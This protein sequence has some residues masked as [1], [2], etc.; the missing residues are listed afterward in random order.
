M[1]ANSASVFRTSFADFRTALKN[2]LG[3]YGVMTNP[4]STEQEILSGFEKLLE[5][6]ETELSEEH[7]IFIAEILVLSH[8]KMQFNAP[9]KVLDL[10]CAAWCADM[11]QESLRH[12]LR[13]SL[14]DPR[15]REKLCT[16]FSAHTLQSIRE[17][18]W[19]WLSGMLV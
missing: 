8:L 3:R 14:R 17:D 11:T 4:C 16:H 19:E 6:R 10:Y 15:F 7:L 12:L 2:L 18:G 13:A 1:N 9:T 5:R